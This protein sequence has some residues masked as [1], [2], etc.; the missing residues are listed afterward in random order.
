MDKK[1]GTRCILVQ[2]GQLEA[3]IATWIVENW[4]DRLSMMLHIYTQEIN[5]FDI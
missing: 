3:R 1:G 2:R 4:G 5:I